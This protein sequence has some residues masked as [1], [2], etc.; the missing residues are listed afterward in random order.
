MGEEVGIGKVD[1][2]VVLELAD[3]GSEVNDEPIPGLVCRTCV[4]VDE[5]GCWAA[6]LVLTVPIMVGAVVD[7]GG[8]V[9]IEL[10]LDVVSGGGLVEEIP[11]PVEDELELAVSLNTISG[12]KG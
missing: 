10:G 12:E 3:V 11:S 5:L 1:K 6:A 9:A 4:V 2:R 8:V 7:A